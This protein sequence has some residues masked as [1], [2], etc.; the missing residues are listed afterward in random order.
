MLAFTA[1]PIRWASRMALLAAAWDYAMG[2]GWLSIIAT[3]FVAQVLWS[4]QR[5]VA[6]TA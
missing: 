3:L 4:A 1:I 6:R 5:A 2:N